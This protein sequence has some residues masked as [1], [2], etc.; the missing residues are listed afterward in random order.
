MRLMRLRE[1]GRHAML[2][3]LNSLPIPVLRIL[4]I[5]ANR[6]YN[7]NHQMNDAALLSRCY[8]QH[9]HRPLIGSEIN[10][11]NILLKFLS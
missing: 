6:F 3:F 2:S 5:E 8:T 9:A 4:D 11:E 10:H 7:R 1:H